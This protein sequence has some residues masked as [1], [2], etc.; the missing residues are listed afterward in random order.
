MMD[1]T[2]RKRTTRM[3]WAWGPI[4]LPVAGA[5]L[6]GSPFPETEAL[7]AKLAALEASVGNVRYDL[8]AGERIAGGQDNGRLTWDIALEQVSAVER[9]SGLRTETKAPNP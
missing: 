8:L 7:R 4:V 2:R 5:A 6:A 9:L 3:G 1:N